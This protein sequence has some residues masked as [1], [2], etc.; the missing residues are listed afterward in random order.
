MHNK[1]FKFFEHSLSIV[2]KSFVQSNN[3]VNLN[4]QNYITAVSAAVTLSS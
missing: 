3:D 4:Y 1:I 2:R